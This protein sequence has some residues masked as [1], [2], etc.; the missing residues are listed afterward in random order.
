MLVR[1]VTPE[2]DLDEQPENILLVE[3]FL[4]A[5][6]SRNTIAPR[7]LAS[8]DALCLLHSTIAE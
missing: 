8:L 6:F 4:V 7:P 1:S 5:R 2:T 3:R